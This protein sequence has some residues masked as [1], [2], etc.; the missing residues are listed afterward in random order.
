MGR[1]E[2]LNQLQRSDIE[3]NRAAEA[4]YSVVIVEDEPNALLRLQ[5]LLRQIPEVRVIAGYKTF[6]EGAAAIQRLQ[7]EVL[8]TD[9]G[10]P[11]G[12]GIDLIRMVQAIGTNALAMAVTVFGDESHVIEAIKAG[13]RGYLL[14]DG[15]SQI[16]LSGVR[17]MLNGGAPISPAIARYLLQRVR[18]PLHPGDSDFSD[19]IL[20]KTE[21]TILQLVSKGYT[22]REI[23]G[24]NNVSHHTVTTHVKNIY[25]KL[26]INSRAEAVVE[27]I[28]LG[29]VNSTIAN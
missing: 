13:A 26:S 25:R 5:T 12:D 15:E 14:K 8:I 22:A 23:G 11:D 29:L 4:R 28:K 21:K 16:I 7:P 2:K 27:A 20:T 17:E 6:A 24:L 18:N 1:E 19:N 9:L 3:D 10:L